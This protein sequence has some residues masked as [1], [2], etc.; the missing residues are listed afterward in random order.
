MAAAEL[1]PDPHDDDPLPVD[2]GCQLG[3]GERALQ[4]VSIDAGV[5]QRLIGVPE[6]VCPVLEGARDEFLLAQGGFVPVKMRDGAGYRRPAEMRPDLRLQLKGQ[7]PPT[8][9]GRVGR[10]LWVEIQAGLAHNAPV[11]LLPGRRETRLQV[12]GYRLQP[13]RIAMSC[14]CSNCKAPTNLV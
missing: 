7:P 6:T 4:A 12:T 10:R 5:Y 13:E 14:A 11:A 1:P 8:R 2:L 9:M 3:E